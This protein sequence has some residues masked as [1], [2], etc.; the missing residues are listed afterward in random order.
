LNAR[1]RAKKRR[2]PSLS[3]NNLRIGIDA[4][5]AGIADGERGGVYQYVS[6]LMR[7]LCRLAPSAE[8]RL[9]FALPRQRHRISI[10]QFVASLQA[11]NVISR[12]TLLPLR[13]LH[14]LHV[15]VD[16]L[17][18]GVD[19]FH[20]PAHIGPYCHA[21]PMVVTVHDLA[22][23]R[24]LGD[25]RMVDRLDAD[26]RRQWIVRQ[27]FFAQL[28]RNV[29]RSAERARLVIAVSHAAAQDLTASLR[30]PASKLRVVQNGLR[31]HMARVT[32]PELLAAVRRRH[33]LE[34][35]DYWLY[36]GV[37][38]PN[39]NLPTMIEAYASYRRGG[40]KSALVIAGRA[41]FLGGTLQALV[42]ALGLSRHVRFLGYVEDEELPAL[43][44]SALGLLMP[45]PLE[46]FGLP[47]LEAMACGTPVIAARSGALP[48]VV[49][50]AGL[51]VEAYDARQLGETM[52]RLDQ[53]RALRTV[54]A[55]AGMRRAAGFS[56]ERAARETLA[57]YA[58][59]VG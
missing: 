11:C 47:A 33:R 21:C 28:S 53:D 36:V 20:A 55:A 46:G 43:Y 48:E 25:G 22:F 2:R 41:R 56:W 26:E 38:D 15:P 34:S 44:S 58:E 45:S 9:M 32:A 50:D 16:V 10:R 29:A 54:L 4:T 24:D 52:Q 5:E 6:Q 37:L 27:R 31:P 39:K 59:A 51:L 1:S 30:V 19:V 7:Q 23:L 17:L 3:R 14:R 18:G 13:W 12:R 49:G 57:V 42:A 8:F 40:G 35:G